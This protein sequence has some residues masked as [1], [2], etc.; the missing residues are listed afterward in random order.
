MISMRRQYDCNSSKQKKKPPEGLK[1]RANCN[2]NT[3][4]T[5][6]L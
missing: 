6:A 1:V 2:D 4:G 5:C 3:K